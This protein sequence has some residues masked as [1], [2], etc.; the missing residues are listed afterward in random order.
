MARP[1][2]KDK[3]GYARNLYSYIKRGIVYFRYIR[4][5]NGEPI[6]LG[7]ISLTD[8]NEA[9]KAANELLM[10]KPKLLDQILVTK[11]QQ[12]L[13][14]EH[15][16]HMTDF[17]QKKVMEKALS[18]N[19]LK[20]YLKYLRSIREQLHS[21][22]TSAITVK[23][24]NNFLETIKGDKA[25]FNHRACLVLIFKRAIGRGLITWNP[26]EATNKDKPKVQRHRLKYEEFKIIY[27][28]ANPV[29]KNAMN[30]ALYSLQR[31]GDICSFTKNNFVNKSGQQFLQVQQG[32]TETCLEIEIIP[33]SPLDAVIRRCW[34]DEINNIGIFSKHLI[35]FNYIKGPYRKKAGQSVNPLTIAKYFAQARAKAMKNDGL[36]KGL[37]KY[38]LPTIHELRSTGAK[39]LAEAGYWPQHMLGHKTEA[40]TQQ[41]LSR[42]GITYNRVPT[43][44]PLPIHNLT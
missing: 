21:F 26:A 17:W 41:Y 34:D 19:T 38:E 3:Q 37:K 43:P 42:H 18:P 12:K 10:P 4:P 2:S 5:D 32:K 9:A 28:Y 40:M 13:F 1:R 16:D 11:E 36:F 7:H 14:D 33:G 29:L 35:H 20:L 15:L 30:M 22:V 8:A 24:C 44:L 23:E 39:R 31:I 6:E 25:R 27:K